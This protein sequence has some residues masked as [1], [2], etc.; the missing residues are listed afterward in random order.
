MASSLSDPSLSS[1]VLARLL[2]PV[3]GFFRGA[4]VFAGVFV[5]F[6]FILGFWA[7]AHDAMRGVR[8]RK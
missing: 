2:V 8:K 7:D 5:A 6:S 1:G 4:L 3:D